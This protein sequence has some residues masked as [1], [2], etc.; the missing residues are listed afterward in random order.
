M[1][2]RKL[3]VATLALSVM[4]VATSAF[5]GPIVTGF[6]GGSSFNIF[7]GASTGDVVGFRF[8]ADAA[9]TL[10]KLGILVDPF[11]GILHS[12]H[13]VGLWRTSDQTLLGSVVV[14]P[15]TAQL[16]D[17]FLY[18]DLGAPIALSAGTGYTL[19]AM[20]TATDS[21]SYLSGPTT[22]STDN[23]SATNGVFPSAGDIG[24]VFPALD[25]ANLARLGPNAIGNVNA[26]IPEPSSLALLGIS[27]MVLVACYWRRTVASRRMRQ[28]A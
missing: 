7:Y 17:G 20:Y 8:T 9:L 10:T 6:T 28:V 18:E 27:V 19:G 16:I 13:E 2:L 25:S 3:Q 22:L 14:N 12:S 21:D 24:F 5:A 11:D 1:R 23:I 15:A 26:A 4:C